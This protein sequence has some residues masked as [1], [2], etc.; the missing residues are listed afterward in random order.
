MLAPA[1]RRPRPRPMEDRT[2]SD[3]VVV[4]VGWGTEGLLGLAQMIAAGWW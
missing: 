1:M 4:M 2:M 3:F